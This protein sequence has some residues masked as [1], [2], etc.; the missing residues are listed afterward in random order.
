[1]YMVYTMLNKNS[2]TVD[3]GTHIS[4]KLARCRYLSMFGMLLLTG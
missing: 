3:P 2:N 1:M 4:F